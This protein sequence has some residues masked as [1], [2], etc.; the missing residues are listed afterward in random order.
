MSVELVGVNLGVEQD[1]EA[2]LAKMQHKESGIFHSSQNH[3]FLF[4]FC[5]SHHLTHT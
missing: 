4:I 5:F 3:E 1:E 2:G